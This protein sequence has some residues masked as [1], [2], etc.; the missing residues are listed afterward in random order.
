MGLHVFHKRQYN[1]MINI[2]KEDISTTK[3][4][5]RLT[6]ITGTLFNTLFSDCKND[7]S[8]AV[9][10]LLKASIRVNKSKVYQSH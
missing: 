6:L 3:N 9:G 4:Q 8:A 2:N 7:R 5:L 10:V 1:T